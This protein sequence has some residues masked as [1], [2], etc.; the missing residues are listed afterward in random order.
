M[1]NRLVSE[2]HLTDELL[3]LRPKAV[4]NAFRAEHFAF[5]AI[6]IYLVFEYVKPDQAYPIFGIL[7]FLQLSLLVAMAG[8]VVDKQTRMARSPL[9]VLVV[10][11]FVH[12]VI[13]AANAYRPDY[14]F[15]KLNIITLWVLI[16]FLITGIVSTERRLFIFVLAYFASN[17]KMSQFG[18]LS[19]VK[20]GF[21]FTSWGVSGAGWFTNSGELG[22]QMAMFFAFSVCMIIFLRHYW[23]GWVKWLMYFLPISAAGCVLASS[24]RGAIVASLAVLF[25]LSMFS[26][27]KI[28][29]WIGS[30]LFIFISYLLMPPEFLA[31][32]QSDGQDAT[33]LSRINYWEKARQMMDEHPWLGVGYYN[34]VPY[35]SDHYFDPS[36]YWRV[37]EAHNTYL[38]M[39]AELGYV[40]LGLF[41]IAVLW[42]FWINWKTERLCRREGFEFLRAFSMGMN[43][44]GVGLVLASLFLTAFF[45]PNYWIHFAF[46]VCLHRIVKE[47]L[48]EI[49][50]NAARG[51]ARRAARLQL[52]PSQN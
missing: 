35:Y 15:D 7:P 19:W 2:P 32:F 12:C 28:R 29:A 49:E 45:M 40:G 23:K 48:A 5:I 41:I 3:A 9:N 34:W 11:F 8:Y 37:E 42:S 26:A 39:G 4:W 10:L 30:G 33:S 47:K 20:R 21:S 50:P 43:A 6:T 31:R 25:Y 38:Q 18:F 1:R 24:S 17:F 14:A 22:L 51:K 16:Y 27:R 36:V 13:S 46:T 52:Q 44:A